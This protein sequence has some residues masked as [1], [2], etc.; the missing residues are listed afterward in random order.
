MKALN[1]INSYVGGMFKKSNLNLKT[2]AICIGCKECS[3]K[4]ELSEDVLKQ[5][6]EN[7]LGEDEEEFIA[8]CDNDCLNCPLDSLCGPGSEFED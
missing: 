4:K 5:M 7:Y 2:K 6:E 1:A 8:I 3:C